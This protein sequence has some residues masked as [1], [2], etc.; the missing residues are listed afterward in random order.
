[1]GSST[2]H[3]IVA[4]ETHFCPLPKIELPSP[5]T[6]DL[7]Q[8]SR[9]SHTDLAEVRGR[10]A[11]ATIVINTIVPFNAET[12]SEECCPHLKFIAVMGVG[13]DTID[14]ATCKRRGIVVSNC[15]GSNMNAVAEHAIGS[16]FALRRRLLISHLGVRAN[17][18]VEKGS[19]LSMIRD[20]DDRPPL[21]ASEETVGIMG[22][23]AIG[24][25]PI[26]AVR[27]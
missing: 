10:I 16:Y 5:Y 7:I 22:F 13:T 8:Y 4:L 18:W 24:E 19:L 23:G 12:L 1:M 11:A 17:G 25:P 3:T 9:T 20:A 26:T 6:F 14:L 15:S 27:I 21:V 2:H